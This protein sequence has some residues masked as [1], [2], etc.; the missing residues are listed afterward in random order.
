MAGIDE[1][2]LLDLMAFEYDLTLERSLIDT[3]NAEAKAE[4]VR[5]AAKAEQIPDDIS[6]AAEQAAL[7]RYIRLVRGSLGLAEA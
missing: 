6:I 5:L 4:H 3:G 2:T 1:A 7:D